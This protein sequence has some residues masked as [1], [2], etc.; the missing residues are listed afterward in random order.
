MPLSCP[1]APPSQREQHK[2]GG[3]GGGGVARRARA[4]RAPKAK[5]CATSS[6]AF[7]AASCA[8]SLTCWR[9][10]RRRRR[11]W[12]CGRGVQCVA[13]V[14]HRCT[15]P[16]VDEEG[17][18]EPVPS[19]ARPSRAGHHCHWA[20]GTNSR[21]QTLKGCMTQRWAQ[22]LEDTRAPMAADGHHPGQHV[23]AHAD[24]QGQGKLRL[25]ARDRLRGKGVEEL[26]AP[27]P[28]KTCRKY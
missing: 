26:S 2:D 20:C 15:H 23:A 12:W 18:R 13:V 5:S 22:R 8:A 4:A 25:D 24:P 28:K 6:A 19:R 10:R 1:V 3:G 21:F 14:A 7:S 27:P 17:P 9:L 16:G 11:W